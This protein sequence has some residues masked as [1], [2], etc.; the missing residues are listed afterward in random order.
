MGRSRVVCD[1]VR[2]PPTRLG[3][4]GLDRGRGALGAGVSDPSAGEHRRRADEAPRAAGE[5]GR[6]RPRGGGHP[7]PAP[8][9]RPGR[10]DSLAVTRWR[11]EPCTSTHPVDDQLVRADLAS[12]SSRCVTV[13]AELGHRDV[14]P[15]PADRPP[16]HPAGQHIVAVGED[17]GPHL[18]GGRPCPWPRRPRSGV[19]GPTALITTRSGGPAT[20][21][22]V[23][24]PA[25]RR[26]P[27]DAT[28]YGHGHE[29]RRQLRGQG[30]APG[31]ARP[32]AR[33]GA[34]P[35]VVVGRSHPGAVSLGR[36]AAVGRERPRPRAAPRPGPGRPVRRP[37]PTTRRSSASWTRSRAEL[38]RYLDSARWFQGR[39]GSPLRS[40][41]YFSPEF[42]IAEAL[43]QYSGGLGVLAG[44]H[45]KA[46]SGLGVPSSASDSSTAMRTSTSS[47]T[48][49]AGSWSVT[50]RSTRTRCRSSSS[51]APPSR[52]SSPAN[53]CTRR[54]GGRASGA[55]RC[56]SSTPTSTA[57]TTTLRQVTDR[58]YGGDH[59]HR[60]RQEIL[61]GMGGV[62]ALDA[63]GRG[64]PA[65]PH[66]R[67]TRRVLHAGADP[68]RCATG[69]VSRCRRRSRPCGRAP[70]SP[71][72]PPCPPASTG[73][74]GR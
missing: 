27:P 37:G 31:A 1:P 25:R 67:R 47:L 16:P 10:A 32:A 5:T 14:V 71:P 2:Q 36:S 4:P 74:T 12:A 51:R 40:V 69:K 65:V 70:C 73:S 8:A 7:P 72:T 56:T 15:P 18:A 43:P 9:R 33:L 60:L 34:Q 61:L 19:V 44:D 29:G 55:C 28:G 30:P 54:S 66:E 68:H 6:V 21:P 45:L 63:L 3:Q 50:R 20:E 49:T 24:V 26:G 53:R 17:V 62:R 57:T 48:L 38:Q 58:L 22:T 35:P 52:S 42:G 11:H 59:E 39:T 46:A 64:P 23:V 13:V 41:A